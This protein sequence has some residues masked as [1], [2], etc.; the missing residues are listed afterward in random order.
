[1]SL[2]QCLCE[3]GDT[4]RRIQ[5]IAVRA[6][7][8]PAVAFGVGRMRAA[9]GG[10]GLHVP[11]APGLDDVDLDADAVVDG[12]RRSQRG[13]ELALAHDAVVAAAHGGVPAL[14]GGATSRS[15]HIGVL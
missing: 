8:D 2:V 10:V 3:V 11:A 7:R 12:L 1:A 15:A 14:I 9:L 5:A 6:A 4:A 13:L